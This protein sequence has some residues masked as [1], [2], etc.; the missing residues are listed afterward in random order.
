MR[1][2]RLQYLILSLV[3]LGSVGVASGQITS[4]P[5]SVTLTATLSESLTVSASPST[6]TFTL[7]PGS[8]AVGSAPVAITTTW[9]TSTVEGH[10]ELDGY[11]SSAS[12]ALTS[13]N[14]SPAVNFPSSAVLGLMGTGLPS[15]YTAFTATNGNVTAATS[16]A[17]LRLFNVTLSSANRSSTRTD[18][19]SLKIDLSS[20]T[21]IPADTYTGTLIL[22][23]Q[24]Y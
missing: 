5:A 20:L 10:L 24:A 2:H 9:N 21:Q 11:F 16:G 12:A 15:S 8:F 22:E 17:T 19:L 3:L 7:T 13:T 23:A 4:S 14:A 6:V 1:L 18:N